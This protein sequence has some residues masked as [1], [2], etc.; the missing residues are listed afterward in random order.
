M[1]ACATA[2]LSFSVLA[3]T[4]AARSQS[5][6]PTTGLDAPHWAVFSNQLGTA[7]DFFSVEAGPAIR[8]TG[9][10]LRSPDGRARM[11][12]Y[13]EDND[14]RHTP[15]SFVQTYLATPRDRLDY[16]RVTNRFFAISGVYDDRIFYSRCNFPAG[17]AGPLHC[18]YLAYPKDEERLWD[19]IV[20]RISRSL[21]PAG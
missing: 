20:T 14:E 5:P 1:S 6:E 8:G 18:V 4:G 19:T 10:D 17:V 13:V 11:M 15:A 16:N 2:A 3:W 9:R 12:V 7:V 21:R